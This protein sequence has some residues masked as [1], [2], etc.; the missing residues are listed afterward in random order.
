MGRLTDTGIKA[1]KPK[2][3]TYQTADGEG[4][5]IEVKTSGR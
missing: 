2:A 4:L 1:L 3:G 5:V